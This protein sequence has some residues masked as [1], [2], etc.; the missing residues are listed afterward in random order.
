MPL[1]KE[2]KKKR[3]IER[4][5]TALDRKNMNSIGLKRPAGW[6]KKTIKPR[7]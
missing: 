5:E 6:E 3:E 4:C 7:K 1:E 2:K